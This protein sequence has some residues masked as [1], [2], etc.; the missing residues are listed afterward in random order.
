[1]VHT[2]FTLGQSPIEFEMSQNVYQF[3]LRF[4]L[5]EWGGDFWTKKA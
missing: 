1:M 3:L 4:G 5:C 2:S